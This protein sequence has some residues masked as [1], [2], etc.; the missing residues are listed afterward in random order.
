MKNKIALKLTL[1]FSGV[2]LVFA[3]IIGSVFYQFFKEHTV[4]IKK[5]EMRL[6]A[7]KIADVLGD[8]MNRMEQKHGS[9]IASSK[10][11]TYLDN[12]T[13][14]IV[15][16]VD[17][18][19]QLNVNKE[20]KMTPRQPKQHH[21]SILSLFEDSKPL[22]APPFRDPPK[23]NKEAYDRLPPQIKEKVEQCFRGKRFA[24]EEYNPMLD[25]IMLTVGQPV[26]DEKGQV[27]A[28][29]LL[30][31]PVSGLREAVWEG[32]RILLISLLA[33]AVLGMLLAVVLSW[34]FT[35]PLN[36][37]KNTA[38]R[39]AERDYAART[40]IHQQDEVG[41]LAQTLDVLAQRLELADAE[42]QKLEKLRREF[43][44]NISHELRTPVTVIRGSL[45]ALRDGVVTD[46]E[47][48]REFH[49][50]MYKESLFLQRLINDLLDLSRLQNTDF[51]IEKAPLN[52]VD[53]IGDAVR[54]SRQIGKEKKLEI[55]S[56]VDKDVYLLNGDY[57]RL[58][59]ML[60]I[61]L[62]N[63][64]KFSPE[65][66]KIEVILQ[67]SKLLVRDHGCGIKPEDVPHAFDRFYKARNEQNKSGSGLGLAIAKQ[68]ALRHEMELS[69]ES[70]V[71]EGTTIVVQ[72]PK[73]LNKEAVKDEAKA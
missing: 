12:V 58:R 20:R 7:E 61:F 51:P 42:S 32:L 38:E 46:K 13:Q 37:M 31:S 50:Q 48:V 54:G 71:G 3:L 73:E 35:K 2:L 16:V 8:N 59:Q 53:V 56:K 70:I 11:I 26:R 49:E 4:D 33:A 18:D 30:H 17:S 24:L 64:I 63:S 52:L 5:Q 15:W 25:G 23:N 62:H 66:G 60:M 36:M 40:N 22:P 44:A 1:Y 55:I 34:R 6:R 21:H 68:I 41:E 19:R 39:L 28:V 9:G 69:L 67:G 27:K 65:G 14:E 29:L 72:L 45:E 43:I 47:D 57:G 10:F